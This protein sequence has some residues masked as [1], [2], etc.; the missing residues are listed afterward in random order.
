MQTTN[1]DQLRQEHSERQEEIIALLNDM[2]E[3]YKNDENGA[4]VIRAKA[5][6][7]LAD[8]L[9][10]GEYTIVVVGEFSAGKS[11][12]LNAMMGENLLPA[13]TNETTATVNF[14][15]HEEQASNGEKGCVFYNDSTSEPL[16]SID[17]EIIKKFV[18]T[19]G[20]DVAK[21]VA[22]LD[23]Y[24][25]SD[26]LRDNVTLIDSPGLNGVAEGHAD[27]TMEQIM[28][29]HACI[30]VFNA[31]QP[32]SKS[33]FEF[34]KQ[35]K[36]DM[37]TIL[38]VL[39]RIDEINASEG[40]TPESVISKVKESYQK[41]FPDSEC[42][43]I[44][45]IA[46][47]QAL[48]S[49]SRKTVEYRG[50][51]EFDDIEKKKMLT[52]SRLEI[53]ETRL[54]EFL[55]KGEKTKQQSLEPVIRILENGSRS[56]SEIENEISFLQEAEDT[57]EIERNILALKDTISGLEEEIDACEADVAS[58]V[59]SELRDIKESIEAELTK[60]SESVVGRMNTFDSVDDI[61]HYIE[62]I[63][64]SYEFKVKSVFNRLDD[65][66]REKVIHAVI[67]TNYGNY[68]NR[69]QEKLSG[70]ECGVII[71][72]ELNLNSEYT[73][74]AGLEKME[75]QENELKAKLELLKM[76]EID[77]ANNRIIARANQVNQERLQAQIYA[78]GDQIETIS[79]RNIAPINKTNIEDERP[80]T[81][82]EKGGIL[83][84]IF[85]S[86]G[87][88]MHRFTRVVINDIEHKADLARR[89]ADLERAR[90]K[91]EEMESKL[92]EEA[93][94]KTEMAAYE[95]ERRKQA[96]EDAHQEYKELLQKNREEFQTKNQAAIQRARYEVET[97]LEEHIEEQIRIFKKEFDKM[98]PI[99]VSAAITVISSNIREQLENRK[100]EM[101]LLIQRRNS[102][103]AERDK[104]ISELNIRLDQLMIILSRAATIKNT[105]EGLSLEKV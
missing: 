87:S 16:E 15:R 84:F 43:E 39:N 80:K 28:Q 68:A 45:P 101:E 63:Q 17:L 35:I 51:K 78:I 53:F 55:T 7:E 14:L 1:A 22:H 92:D 74:H 104:R 79:N 76:Q 60:Y 67:A 3:W 89:E 46:A 18:S 40:D 5:Y 48:V 49:R 65:E 102:S 95:Y 33:N 29:S 47:K 62:G 20:E 38:F 23:L 26:F 37:S 6:A 2:Y 61:N 66:L 30:F 9:R 90:K 44:Y 98:Q 13:Y 58:Q 12:M 93:D 72:T 41:F 42:P 31:A 19:K 73:F 75:Q 59:R 85:G 27:I 24:L 96:Y 88:S 56:K 34:L 100:R 69:I 50:K 97:N 105:L 57:G 32:G 99:Y 77:A 82:Q 21:N 70:L 64:K 91:A 94:E 52:S 4:S 10:S 71:P 8:K 103:E 86:G 36:S 25:D 83:G 81:F 54:M 11:T